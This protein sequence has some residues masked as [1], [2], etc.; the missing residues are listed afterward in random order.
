MNKKNSIALNTAAYF[1]SRDLRMAH[2]NIPKFKIER[3]PA[4]IHELC[5]L[6]HARDYSTCST[7]GTTF[8]TARIISQGR[9]HGVN[10]SDGT[11]IWSRHSG[12]THEIAID[13]YKHV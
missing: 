1:S 2:Y 13:S 9:G 3:E 7:C 6:H 12:Y 5:T 10:Y 4:R 11:G 8:R